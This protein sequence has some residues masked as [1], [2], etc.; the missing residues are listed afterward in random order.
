VAH[1]SP[2]FPKGV[3]LRADLASGCTTAIA[4]KRSGRPDPILVVNN[5]VF[6]DIVAHS[7]EEDASSLRGEAAHPIHF[8]FSVIRAYHDIAAEGVVH[9]VAILRVEPVGPGIPYHV[10]VNQGLV[11]S[12]NCDAHMLPFNNSIALKNTAR[13]NFHEMEVKAVPAHDGSLAAPF[14]PSIAHV[15]VA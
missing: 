6:N 8:A 12:M 2:P 9:L 13:A 1:V 15:H 3:E 11:G 5:T 4:S 7:D 10:L 14:H